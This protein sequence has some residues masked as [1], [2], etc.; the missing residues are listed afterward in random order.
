MV[1]RSPV[2]VAPEKVRFRP[3]VVNPRGLVLVMST[4]DVL[5]NSTLP[6]PTRSATSSSNVK[7]PPLTV[8]RLVPTS[9]TPRC[10]KPGAV[11][12]WLTV[13][14]AARVMVPLLTCAASVRV[15]ASGFD[16]RSD[17]LFTS[18]VLSSPPA[19][20]VIVPSGAFVSVPATAS[21][22]GPWKV[23]FR[24]TSEPLFTK[25]VPM[26]APAPPASTMAVGAVVR[27]PT[28]DAPF[29]TS[30]PA[31]ST[32]AVALVAVNASVPPVVTRIPSVAKSVRPL[33]ARV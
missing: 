28:R 33:E 4:L 7:P 31:R 24:T 22:A 16:T 10:V 3:W 1:I 21:T 29:S 18:S 23:K 9:I 30:V 13:R 6:V 32:S 19:V 2:T 25:P 11:P 15:I 8:S 5:M 12:D 20:L 26:L 17:P 14:S 27:A